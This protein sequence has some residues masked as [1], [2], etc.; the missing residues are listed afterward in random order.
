MNIFDDWLALWL[1]LLIAKLKVVVAKLNQ[2][3]V[4]SCLINV[5]GVLQF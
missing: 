1:V 2:Q 5:V 3:Y 4:A